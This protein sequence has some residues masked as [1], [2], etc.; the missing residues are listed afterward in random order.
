MAVGFYPKGDRAFDRAIKVQ[1]LTI[2]FLITHN[3]TP[4]S[5][6]LATDEASV[7]FLQTQGLTQISTTSGAL[8][9]GQ[10]VPT[11]D[12]AAA[13][14]SG[15][16]NLLV[17]VNIDQPVK[18]MHATISDRSVGT[19]YATYHNVSNPD[20]VTGGTTWQ[21]LLNCASGVNLSTTDLNGCLEIE[22]IT[23]E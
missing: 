13:D 21:M 5:K 9:P 1:R 4:A 22:Y 7:L 12:L 10:S 18:I 15:A 2:P 19:N 17:N 14:A 8:D 23:A 3:A 6:T 16:F 20:I 11:L